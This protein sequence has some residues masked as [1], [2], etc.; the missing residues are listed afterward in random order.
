[1]PAARAS[2]EL[3]DASS[4]SYPNG[5]ISIFDA[6]EKQL[7]LKLAPGK[8]TMPVVIVDHLEEK[9]TDNWCRRTRKPVVISS[10]DP[11]SVPQAP[12]RDT[13]SDRASHITPPPTISRMSGKSLTFE[14]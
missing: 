8:R 11:H 13:L 3:P 4:S 2:A 14:I 7:G 10:R 6:L 9:P 12:A 5:A 1:M